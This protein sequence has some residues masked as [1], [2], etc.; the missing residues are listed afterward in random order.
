MIAWALIMTQFAPSEVDSKC[1]AGYGKS[2]YIWII[3]GPMLAALLVR[4]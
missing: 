2:G 3:T 1:W 4:I